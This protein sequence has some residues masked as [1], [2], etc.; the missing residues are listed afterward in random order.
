L[1]RLPTE[2]AWR[3]PDGYP[4]AVARQIGRQGRAV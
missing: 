2:L 4:E 1:A 3:F